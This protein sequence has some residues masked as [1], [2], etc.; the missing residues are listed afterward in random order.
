MYYNKLTNTGTATGTVHTPLAL[1]VATALPPFKAAAAGTKSVTVTSK[2]PV[3]LAPGSYLD[4]TVNDNAT[5]TLSGGSYAVRNFTAGAHAQ[6]LFA[7]STDLK[8]AGTLQTDAGTTLAPKSGTTLKGAD[9]VIYVA[10]SDG[11]LLG[12]PPA[13][14]FGPNNVVTANCYAPN[15]TIYGMFG[16]KL[17]GALLGNKVITGIGVQLSLSTAF[18]G[19]GKAGG[20]EAQSP[21]GEDPGIPKS[22]GLDQNYPNPFNPVTTIGYRLPVD[23]RVKI[24]IFN[25][26]GQRVATLIDEDQIAG[27]H[28]LLWS[29]TDSRGLKVNSG[30]YFCR[31]TAKDYTE[32]RKMMVLK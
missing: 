23:C 21:E 22:F 25:I 20:D 18:S 4:I 17:T 12:L 8:V 32:V 5:L 2:T 3:T 11:P 29:G 9:I 6:I 31:L 13:A 1:P 16:A 24:D 30:V 14:L 28:R 26:L 19:L 10:G 15:G 27:S 7:A